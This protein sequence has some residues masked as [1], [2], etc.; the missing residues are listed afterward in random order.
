MISRRKFL[1]S[2][3]AATFAARTAFAHSDIRDAKRIFMGT[4]SH[5]PGHGIFT[6]NWNAATGEIGSITLAAEV[7]NPTFLAT[8]KKGAET[9]VY[10]VTEAGGDDAKVSAFT[11][12][13]GQP[14]LSL[15]NASTTLG[16]GPTYVSVSPNGRSVFI[17]NYGGGSVTSYRVLANGGLSDP[18]SHFQF[19][20]SGSYKGRQE[21]PHTHSAMTSPDGKFVLVNDLGLDRIMIYRL[22]SATAEMIPCDPPYFSS[23]PGSGPRHLAWSSNGRFVYCDNELDSTID[24]LTWDRKEDSLS[25]ISSLS[26]LREGFPKNTAFVGEVV[27]SKDGRNIYAGNR[28]ADDTIAVFDVNKRTGMLHQVQLADSGGKNARHVALDTSQRWMVISHQDSNDLTVLERNRKTGRLS[29]PVH[30]YP[31]DKPMCVVFTE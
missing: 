22:N 23:R 14:T 13:A 28:V 19:S 29:A 10:A 26:T 9:I 4:G 7:A 3:P 1:L 25:L 27:A 11:T 31:L 5:G 30:S 15:I 18:V 21:K 8:Y 17:A 12:V 20:G 6:A 2:L 24:V 16:G